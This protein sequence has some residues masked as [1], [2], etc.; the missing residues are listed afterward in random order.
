MINGIAAKF[1]GQCSFEFFKYYKPMIFDKGGTLSECPDRLFNKQC[2]CFYVRSARSHSRTHASTLTLE[3]DE[4]ALAV[5]GAV[6]MMCGGEVEVG[7]G[8]RSHHCVMMIGG[9]AVVVRAASVH[10]ARPEVR[11]QLT[12]DAAAIVVAGRAAVLLVR[13]TVE[14]VRRSFPRVPVVHIVAVCVSSCLR[15]MK[16]FD[17]LND[18]F[19]INFGAGDEKNFQAN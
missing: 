17:Q 4:V 10:Y 5:I 6:Q 3:V 15:R 12:A 2:V 19:G 16:T 18:S 11:S 8:Q 7:I 1:G 9:A 14:M 13:G